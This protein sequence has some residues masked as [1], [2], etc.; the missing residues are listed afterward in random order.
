MGLTIHSPNNSID[1]SAS[2]FMKLRRTIA[3]LFNTEVGKHYDKLRYLITDGDCDK[4]DRETEKLV[5]K[6]GNDWLFEFLYASDIED[7]LTYGKCRK[8][9]E[10]I[11]DYDDD[12]CYGYAGLP[13]CAKMR[14]FKEILSDCVTNK[15][16]MI[17]Y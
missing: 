3:F 1:M 13:D 9:L 4:Y 16:Q 11:G 15:R 10:L 12:I 8:L 7:K 2:G 14:D 6:Y 17:W 5:Q